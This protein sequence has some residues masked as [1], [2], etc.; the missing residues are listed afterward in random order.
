MPF[1]AD[2]ENDTKSVA[3]INKQEITK[4]ESHPLPVP[5]EPG[6]KKETRILEPESKQIGVEEKIEA[7]P[8]P[9]PQILEKPAPDAGTCTPGIDKKEKKIVILDFREEDLKHVLKVFS[10]LTHKNVVAKANIS[11]MKISIYLR[12][13][14][15]M[16][17][18]EAI[19]EQYTLWYEET[20]EY[21]KIME[22]SG[23]IRVKRGKVSV[24]RFND[25]PLCDALR[26]FSRETGINVTANEN[27]KDKKVN[28]FLKNV[29][30]LTAIELICK[31]YNLWYEKNK[32]YI[33][34]MK[35][36][37]FGKEISLDY[38]VKSKIFNLKYAS[39]PQVAD[40]I[41]CVMGNRVEYNVPAQL[42]SY[43]HIK[44]PDFEED[45]GKIEKA[46]T[47]KTSVTEGVE[48]KEFGK[49]LTSKKLEEILKTRLG[50]RLTAEDIRMINKE[51]GFAL[52]TVFIR[53]NSVLASSTDDRVLKEIGGIIQ[54]LDIPTPQVLIECKILKVSLSDEFTSFFD[55]T[56]AGLGMHHD[57]EVG[58]SPG[59][60]FTPGGALST[61]FYKFIAP[62]DYKFSV[63]MELLQK[64]GVVEITGTPMIVTAQNAEAEFFSGCEDWPF[65]KGIHYRE[66]EERYEG[67]G[68]GQTR[69]YIDV[70]TALEDVGTKLRVT[71][72]INEDETVT[73]RI[74]IE[75]G[76]ARKKATRIPYWNPE[77]GALSEYPVDVKEKNNID[78]IIT[79]PDG[80][81][82]ALG[83]LVREEDSEVEEGVPFLGKL[84]LIG[85]F[86]RDKQ[87]VKT[88]TEMVFL[89]TPHIM[90]NPLEVK[91]TTKEV[92][93][94]VSRHPYLKE[95]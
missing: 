27:I 91:E 71:P 95:D 10:A 17:A 28:L 47:I 76:R 65:V 18:L 19:C 49:N 23:R 24:L 70:D 84:P 80:H 20:K 15:P 56:Y 8:A 41:G 35:A 85:F 60:A 29:S 42:K 83:G 94:K 5:L 25:Q 59:Q 66:V 34:L 81:T 88:K 50:L 86:F 38:R 45:E 26:I 33:R 7:H 64:D 14:S 51:M 22:F 87:V 82:L 74:H 40:A 43:E 54:Q 53:N 77:A 48:T 31:K 75:E 44:L 57:V 6:V 79:I 3:Q 63:A 73:L 11:D 16:A 32:D 46:K 39:A 52:M 62:D 21:I 2:T 69:Y 68:A 90:M 30:P 72:Q 58:I 1:N 37:D 4:N 36:E 9:E 93:K 92:L 55:I 67:G 78:T 61:I 12:D 13:I 89:L